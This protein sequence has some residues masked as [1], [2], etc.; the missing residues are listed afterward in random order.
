VPLDERPGG[1]AKAGIGDVETP[2]VHQ[3]SP[4]R[5]LEEAAW[6]G[7]TDVRAAEQEQA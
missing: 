5:S 7:G 3:P 4:M 6:V 2:L 1:G